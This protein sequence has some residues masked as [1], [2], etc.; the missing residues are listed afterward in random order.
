MRAERFLKVN[1]ARLVEG[2]DEIACVRDS[3]FDGCAVAG[4]GA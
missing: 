3:P 1:V 2:A 4:I